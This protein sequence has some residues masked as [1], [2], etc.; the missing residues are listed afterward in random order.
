MGV[1][2]LGGINAVIFYCQDIFE[3]AGST[4]PD[5]V[6]AI[7]VGVVQVVATLA[8]ASLVDRA[9]R[10]PLLL[11]S[12]GLMALCQATLGLCL[13]LPDAL[14]GWLALVAVG[15]FIIAFS[16]GCGPLPWMMLGE[17][18]APEGTASGLAVTLNWVIVFAVTF[19][20]PPANDALGGV[21]FFF[22][23]AVCALG[24]AFVLAV[25]PETKGKTLQEIQDALSGDDKRGGRPV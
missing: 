25:V 22:F 14:P 10:R 11:V 8:A 23:A 7:I 21:T 1:Q 2:Q 6:A 15:V 19:A 12:A 20:F 13:K 16:L 17:I 5:A 4:I 18:F 3:N 24:F 9:G